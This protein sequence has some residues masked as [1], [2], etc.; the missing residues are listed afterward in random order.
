M[1]KILFVPAGSSWYL[2]CEGC[3]NKYLKA[4]RNEKQ[5]NSGSSYTLARTLSSP[6][7]PSPQEAHLA[8]K[9]NAMFLLELSSSTDLTIDNK[10]RHSS[11]ILPSVSENIT[12]P[13]Y[14]G[15]FG[16]PPPF[17]CLQSLG[18]SFC[19]DN[20]I[21]T[22]ILRNHDFEENYNSASTS[23]GQRV[24]ML[25]VSNMIFV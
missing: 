21:Y 20:N 15:P 18:I 4:L 22:N 23:F 25:C 3:R 9:Q 5:T 6:S 19:K 13:D 10:R 11:S 2:L 1:L 16:P 8:M 12:P 7:M 17:Q 24:S 14:N